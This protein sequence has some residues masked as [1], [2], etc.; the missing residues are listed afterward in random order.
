MSEIN[1]ILR[2]IE[3]HCTRERMERVT[4][5]SIGRGVIR[6]SGF[7]NAKKIWIVNREYERRSRPE[8][9]INNTIKGSMITGRQQYL[10]DDGAPVSKNKMY[11]RILLENYEGNHEC[12]TADG[13]VFK[14]MIKN[15]ESYINEGKNVRELRFGIAGDK[16][17]SRYPTLQAAIDALSK[18]EESI[19]AKQKAEEFARKKAEEL[20]RQ[21][22]EEEAKKAEEEARRIEDERKALEAERQALIDEYSN[23]A[24]FIREQVSLRNNPVLDKAQNDAKF[25]NV[26]NGVAEVVNGGPG[27]GK[28]TTMIQRL[29]LLIDKGDLEDYRLNYQGCKLSNRDIEIASGPDNWI[30]FSPNTLLK[31]YLEANMNYEGLTDTYRRTIVWKDFLRNAV[32]DNYH[33]AG[34]GDDSPFDFP[35]HRYEDVPFFTGS[36][37]NVISSF[38]EYFIT[39]SKEKYNKIAKID[40]NKFEWKILG[41]IIARE[42]AKADNVKT[43]TELL[44][45][46]IH[47]ESADEKIF[48]DGHKLTTGS[49]LNRVFN[50]DIQELADDT[51][52]KLKNNNP[53]AYDNLEKYIND[54]LRQ[55]SSESE[56]DEDEELTEDNQSFGNTTLIINQKLISLLKKLA[57]RT[58]DSSVKIQGEALKIYEFF[59]DSINESRLQELGQNAYFVKYMYP[60]VRSSINSI[61]SSVPRIYKS[62][63]KNLPDNVKGN[64]DEQILQYILETTKNRALCPQEQSLLVGFINRICR[65]YYKVRKQDFEQSNHKYIQAYKELCRPVI[66][67]DEATDYCIID[68]FGIRSFGHYELESFTLCGDSMQMMREDGISNWD[69]LHHP[70]IF[71]NLDIKNLNVSYRQSKELMELAGKIYQAELGRPSPYKCHLNNENTPKPLWIEND[72]IDD[73]AEWITQRVLEINAKYNGM[74]TIAVFTKDKETCERL[75][76]ALDDCDELTRSGI[77]ARVCSENALAEPKILRIFP[78]DEVKGME[79]EAVFFYDIDDIDSTSLVN[80]YLYVGISR[81]AFYL[82]VTSNGK[83]QRIKKLLSG[84]FSQGGDW[85]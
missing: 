69:I 55:K 62:F 14:F 44:Q 48:I 22:Q 43:L 84:Y 6:I 41:S 10:E 45:F 19:I 28:T 58:V 18:N 72:D 33:L 68:Y 32:R 35:K 83:S 77:Q 24:A 49:E 70:L 75:R 56:E 13:R 82:A 38:I 9:D 20:R 31:K 8:Y 40:F 1:E 79:F 26:F 57:L 63:R 85:R 76:E 4:D 59:K 15:S 80:K 50:A 64:C 74:P 11:G 51:R 27:T 60:A 39:L 47:M 42:C 81:A 54:S 25:S 2:D 30:Y 78:I 67:I 23:Q 46:L 29:K 52:A 66:G 53:S 61:F 71:G 37:F 73:K 65:D 16:E 3:Q 21:R 34:A 12:R 5:P 36:H 17:W 7:P